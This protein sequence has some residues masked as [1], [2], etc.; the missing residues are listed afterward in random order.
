MA[1]EDINIQA[2]RLRDI[3]SR[4][5]GL[6]LAGQLMATDPTYR[7]GF[8]YARS[9][10]GGMPFEDV[11]A[12]GMS[13]SPDRPMGYTQED[14]M[15]KFVSEG[16]VPVMPVAPT[17]GTPVAPSFPTMPDAPVGTPMPTPFVPRETTFAEIPKVLQDLDLSAI[18][19]IESPKDFFKVD[20][21]LM[22]FEEIKDKIDLDEV[23]KID[24]EKINIPE[25]I[26]LFSDVLDKPIET[27]PTQPT[28]PSIFDQPI[29]P[30][31]PT[32]PMEP[33]VQPITAPS[34]PAQ[35]L[36]QRIVADMPVPQPLPMPVTPSFIQPNI[37]EI[38][39]PMMRGRTK[40]LPTGLFDLA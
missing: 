26:S 19:S 28:L 39:S 35:T 6:N 21:N 34:I 17:K 37:E 3:L 18:P 11:V 7:S 12:P 33:M 40:R 4:N 15:P 5:P 10:A 24:I 14:L 38:I 8:D 31:M 9:I 32:I 25:S 16:P 20:Q 2:E 27:Q 22:N 23:A 13:F 1:I 36:P 30:V 29:A